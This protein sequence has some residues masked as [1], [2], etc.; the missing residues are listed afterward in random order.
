MSDSDRIA[1]LRDL[2]PAEGFFQDKEWV[3]SPRAFPLPDAIVAL[4]QGLGASLR[5]FQV[6]CEELYAESAGAPGG[7]RGWVARLL[8]AGKPESVVEL[9]RETSWHGHLPRVIRPDLMLTE[10]GVSIAELDSLPGGMGLTAW[11]NETYAELGDEVI[12]GASGMVEGFRAAFP[13]EAIVVSRESAD[14]E[15]EMRWLADRLADG[16]PVL[17]P[18]SM[19]LDALHGRSIYRFFE[20]FDLPNVEHSGELVAMAREGRLE[21]TPPLRAFLEEKLWL[22][23]FW[24]PGLRGFWEEVLEREDVELLRRCVPQG[25]VMDPA[26]LPAF[27]EIA[28]LGAADWE[29]VAA[30]GRKERELVVKISG[31][32]ELGWGS[33]GVHIGHDLSQVEW[34]EALRSALAAHDTQPHLMQRFHAARVV[35][36]P[37]WD[38]AAGVSRWVASRVRLCPY[39]FVPKT[40]GVPGLGGVLATVCP[41]D[42]KLLHGM[43][44]A[45]MLP[46]CQAQVGAVP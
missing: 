16:R 36:H 35:E 25:W 46:C 41:A 6:A 9:A 19:D 24:S 27:G 4:I 29:A 31:F 13:D 43:R 23:L 37:A 42:K 5:R 44:D 38:E 39:Y 14:Y 32:S 40:G 33:R 26:A 1:R 20:L 30:L 3:L 2:F 21:V 18:W 7:K 17:N 12:G 15:P 22:A 34:A 45:M 8:D 11:L 28:G 10:E